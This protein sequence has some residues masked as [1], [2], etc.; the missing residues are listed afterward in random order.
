MTQSTVY[1][2]RCGGS[3]DTTTVSMQL[4]GAGRG[5]GRDLPGEGAAA[6]VHRVRGDLP[7]GGAV[8]A[9]AGERGLGAG[10]GPVR[11]HG[12]HHLNGHRAEP[13]V[14]VGV[15]ATRG[16]GGKALGGREGEG[17]P[18]GAIATTR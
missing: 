18:R 5:R 16:N 14:L 8:A 12:R 17:C 15:V 4:T 2:W 11:R 3:H 13:L 9:L 6:Q 10:L 1:G 7:G